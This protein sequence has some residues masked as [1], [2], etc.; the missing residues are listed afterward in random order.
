MAFKKL[1][2]MRNFE[3][4]EQFVKTELLPWKTYFKFSVGRIQCK[5]VRDLIAGLEV[6]PPTL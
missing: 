2:N 3:P 1:D 6:G 5:D 4:G